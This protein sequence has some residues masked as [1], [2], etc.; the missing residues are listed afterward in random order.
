[1]LGFRARGYLRQ[2]GTAPR[3]AA[4]K[5]SRESGAVEVLLPTDWKASYCL[6]CIMYSAGLPVSRS[7]RLAIGG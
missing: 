5:S 2:S 3:A 1:M 7:I 6:Y 4:S